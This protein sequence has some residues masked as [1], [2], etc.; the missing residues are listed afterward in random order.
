MP[1]FPY[2]LIFVLTSASIMHFNII[3]QYCTFLG[4]LSICFNQ[5]Y[6][7]HTELFLYVGITFLNF[8]L[9]V[10]F[11]GIELNCMSTIFTSL[12]TNTLHT[13]HYYFIL[14]VALHLMYHNSLCLLLFFLCGM[15][16]T[17]PFHWHIFLSIIS[18]QGSFISTILTF[19]HLQHLSL[20][21]C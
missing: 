1:L 7:A 19:Q 3:D 13:F 11:P 14:Q 18:W 10:P 20:Y 8:E 2:G 4:T 17:R 5:V 16:H 15:Q 9:I 6:K 21:D 12:V